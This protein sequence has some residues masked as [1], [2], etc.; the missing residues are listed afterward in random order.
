MESRTLLLISGMLVSGVCNTI[1]NKL[2]DMTCVEHCDDP[3]RSKHFEQPVWQTFNMFIGETLCFI[4]VHAILV[5]EYHKARTY[6]PLAT[7]STLAP[8]V[9]S[10]EIT[11]VE[12]SEENHGVTKVEEEELT[13]WLVYLLW[14]PTLCDICGTTV[15]IEI[16]CQR[17]NHNY[18]IV[19]VFFFFSL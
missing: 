14:L 7:D 4:L 5:W 11:I 3:E 16:F 15:C 19:L 12:E 13:G 8:D 17:Y 6:T 18:I 1:F 9:N 2:Q 10:G